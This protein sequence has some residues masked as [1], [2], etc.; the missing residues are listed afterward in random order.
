[1]AASNIIYAPRDVIQFFIRILVMINLILMLYIS[2]RANYKAIEGVDSGE[3]KCYL[4]T[5]IYT[6]VIFSLDFL[7][8]DV[9]GCSRFYTKLYNFKDKEEENTILQDC[10]T[11]IV[12]VRIVI[13]ILWILAEIFKVYFSLKILKYIKL[14]FKSLKMNIYENTIVKAE[15]VVKP[16]NFKKFRLLKLEF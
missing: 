12:T 6:L 10:G 7:I 3:Y 11:T 15:P 1:M 4:F 8:S 5:Q 16:L 9:F 2:F 14:V 13:R